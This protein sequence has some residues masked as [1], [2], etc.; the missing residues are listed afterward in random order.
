MVVPLA[1]QN[2]HWNLHLK[3]K[4]ILSKCFPSK[5]ASPSVYFSSVS[6][7]DSIIWLALWFDDIYRT[8][9]IILFPISIVYKIFVKHWHPM[10]LF[11]GTKIHMS[12]NVCDIIGSLLNDNT[13]RSDSWMFII[14]YTIEIWNN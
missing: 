9:I 8:I 14:Y 11:D 10:H 4:G 2:L 1:M 12:H 7:I 3:V 5:T 13:T 6:C